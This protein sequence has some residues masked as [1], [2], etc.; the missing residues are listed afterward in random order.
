MKSTTLL[1]IESSCDE[2]GVSVVRKEGVELRVLSELVASQAN[3]HK[4]TGGVVPEV[5]AREHLAVIGP[6]IQSAMKQ[7]GID[8]HGIDGIAVTIG[9][10]LMPALA[11]GVQAAKTLAFVWRKPI[12][13]VHHIEGHIYSA[14][15]AGEDPNS[16]TA[17]LASQQ[18]QAL[19]SAM[20]A[21][22]LVVSGG[23]TMLIEVTDHLTYSTLGQTKD[24]A[25][26]EVFDKVARMLSLPYPGGPHV[27]ALAEQGDAKAYDFPRPMR[28]SGDLHFS[29]SGLKTAVLYQLQ[30]IGETVSDQDR[31]SIAAS[32]EA[33]V[34]DSL[35]AKLVQ[36]AKQKQYRTVLLAGGVAANKRLR[37]RMQEEADALGVSL[38]IAP[39][40]LCGDNATM[41][42]QAGVFAYEAGRQK[43]WNEIDASARMDIE[44]FSSEKLQA[45]S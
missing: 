35:A 18:V 4:A 39:Q 30:S 42:G 20:P 22:G 15:L 32:F 44:E 34:I 11:V 27:S 9:P 28:H 36:A 26:G 23:H 25:A 45:N 6:M 16:Y 37:A 31:A 40:A 19:D 10:G 24:D 33:A 17:L 8:Q 2:T 13:P 7:A 38:R 12:V 43:N 21:L 14:L 41:I 1:A 29:Y 3:I 5:A